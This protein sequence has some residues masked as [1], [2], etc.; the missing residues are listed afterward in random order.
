MLSAGYKT[1][2]TRGYGD[3]C[4]VAVVYK[5]DITQLLLSVLC[6]A[7]GTFSIAEQLLC[8][9]CMHELPIEGNSINFLL[10]F[11]LNISTKDTTRMDGNISLTD[12]HTHTHTRAHTAV[13]VCWWLVSKTHQCS[14]QKTIFLEDCT[15]VATT[16]KQN[17]LFHRLTQKK[18]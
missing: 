11:L 13:F 10:T 3:G 18:T 6:D 14:Q 7:S 16:A 17:Q 1:E 5:W 4:W 12:T 15:V 8:Y 2:S 9:R